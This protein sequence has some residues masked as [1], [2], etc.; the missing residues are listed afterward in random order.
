MRYE[1]QHQ[2]ET[3]AENAV[4]AET[5]AASFQSLDICFSHWDF[6]FRDGWRS[7]YWLATGTVDGTNVEDAY[8]RFQAKL[9][10]VIPRVA[11]IGQ[12]YV[13][14]VLQPFLILR[15]DKDVGYF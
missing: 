15:A 5:T 3:L 2:I 13:E 10:R 1:I 11:L 14:S 8:K 9:A 12:C 4:M 6:N 7:T